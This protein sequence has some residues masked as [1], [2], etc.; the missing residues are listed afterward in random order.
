MPRG[1]QRDLMAKK[2]GLKEVVTPGEIAISNM[3]EIAALMEVLER[4][5]VW[6]KHEVLD[7][8]QELRRKIPKAGAAEEAF[9]DSYTEL[10]NKEKWAMAC[11]P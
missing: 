7:M 8:I 1:L 4:K 5:G 3:W 9:R 11:L 10:A 2:I 6:T